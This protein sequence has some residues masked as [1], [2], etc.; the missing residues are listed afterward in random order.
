MYSLGNHGAS[1][2]TFYRRVKGK[3]PSVLVVRTAEN[4]VFGGFTTTPW[5]VNVTAT[6][7]AYYGTGESFLFKLN[8]GREQQ[9]QQ[10][11]REEEQPQQQHPKNKETAAARAV[12][13]GIEVFPWSRHNNYNMMS[14]ETSLAMGGGGGSYGLF[15]GE[16][17]ESGVSGS[18]ET[19]LNPPLASTGRH[20]D[21]LD[22]EWCVRRLRAR[23]A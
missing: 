10:I 1:Y 12:R 11:Q 17:F 21:V 4:E 16:N 8:G 9:Q 15:I 18:C 13:G 19:Y 22:L 20:F 6:G 14:T 7:P 5:A 3:T 2:S 23:K